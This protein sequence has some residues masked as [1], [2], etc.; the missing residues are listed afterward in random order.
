[1]EQY[2]FLMNSGNGAL[3]GLVYLKMAAE[4]MNEI[5]FWVFVPNVEMGKEVSCLFVL[6][7]LVN[8]EKGKYFFCFVFVLG[9]FCVV[10]GRL[11]LNEE[12]QVARALLGCSRKVARAAW[13]NPAQPT[14]HSRQ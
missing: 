10:R 9:G 14:Y 4:L 13:P 3:L 11:I 7:L 8:D 5:H 12:R 1:M 6:K 2:Y